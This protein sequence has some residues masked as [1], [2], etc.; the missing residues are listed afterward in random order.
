MSASDPATPDESRAAAAASG[1]AAGEARRAARRT[2]AGS[3]ATGVI[4]VGMSIAIWWPAFTLG[5]WGDFFFD[6][7]LTV[8]AA[9]VGALI[10]VLIQPRGKPRVG[11]AI[12]LLIPSLWLA[13]SFLTADADPDDL[14]VALVA[15]LGALVAILA[16]PATIWVLARII[17]PEFAEDISWRRRLAVIGA[18][19]LI[20]VA[21]FFL[22][23]NQSKFLTCGDFTISGNSEPPGCTPGDPQ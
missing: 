11:R 23:A 6:Q 14:V 7:M 20:A 15:V 4:V 17:W 12:A 2:D 5:A 10:V 1:A 3:R 18:V 13:L 22:G 8:W 16:V 9:S 21:S 19:L